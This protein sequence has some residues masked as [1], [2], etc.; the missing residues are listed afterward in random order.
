M[1]RLFLGIRL[2]HLGRTE[3]KVGGGKGEVNPLKRKVASKGIEIINGNL[4]GILFW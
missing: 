4:V 3:I 1:S 2:S